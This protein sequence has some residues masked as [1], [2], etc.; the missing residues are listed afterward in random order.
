VKNFTAPIASIRRDGGTQIRAAL[1][2]ATVAAY[3][4]AIKAGVKLPPAVVFDDEKT[5][6]L[7]DGFHRIEAELRAGKKNVTIERKPGTQRDAILYAVGANATHGL[8]RSNADKRRGVEA[9]LA[10]EEW[11]QWSDRVIAKAAHVGVELVARVRE[12]CAATRNNVRTDNA[13]HR[14]TADGREYPIKQRPRDSK[15]GQPT[16]APPAP[17]A[18]PAL[19]D[20]GAGVPASAGRG[21]DATLAAPAPDEPRGIGPSAAEEAW[22]A[23]ERAQPLP[24]EPPPVDMLGLEASGEWMDTVR[25]VVSACEAIDRE[26]RQLMASARSLPQPT[27]QRLWSALH[28]AAACARAVRPAVACPFCKA[29]G[30]DCL[31]CAGN[32]WLSEEGKGGV[33]P[34]VLKSKV[35][36]VGRYSPPAKAIHVEMPDGSEYEPVDDTEAF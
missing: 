16:A 29:A 3:A 14:V 35:E 7:A 1:D 33:H 8:P 30:G 10:D 4:E 36:K 13:T 18:N 6:W 28:D 9:V 23:A 2:E 26:L 19:K 20:E 34:A 25:I 32:G 27:Q 17:A 22:F 12:E 11:S 15:P 5:L 21:A 24:D 31:S